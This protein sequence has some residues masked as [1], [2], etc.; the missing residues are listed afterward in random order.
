MLRNTKL[1]VAA[2]FLFIIATVASAFELVAYYTRLIPSRETVLLYEDQISGKWADLVVRLG[3]KGRVVFDRKTSY[4]P[5]WQTGTGRWS[6]DEIIPRNGDGEEA[7]PDLINRYSHV[8]LIKAEKDQV[9]VHWRYVPDFDNPGLTGVVDEYFT[10]SPDGLVSRSVRRATER[11]DD[12]LDPANVT[13]QVLKLNADGIEQLSLKKPSLARVPAEAVQGSPVKT[14][15][16]VK[17]AAWWKF[18][19]GLHERPYERKDLAVEQISGADCV[20]SGPKTLYKKGVSGTALEFDGYYT[21]VVLPASNAPQIDKALTV[22]AWV[23]LGAY[24][25]GWAPVVQQSVWG[26]SGYYLGMD[27]D[28]RPGFHV[29]VGGDWQSLTGSKPLGLFRWCHLAGTFDRRT[30]R[31]SLFVDGRQVASKEIPNQSITQAGTDLVIGLNTQKM[32]PVAGRVR[33]GKWPSMFGIDGLIDEVRIYTQALSEQRIEESYRLFAPAPEMV[34]KPDM[35]PRHWPVNPHN[36]PSETFGAKYTK[37]SYYETWDNIWR[38]SNHPDIL[39]GFDELPC[40]VVFWRGTSYGPILVTENGKWVGDQSSENYRMVEDAGEAEGCC[41]HMSDKQCRHSHVRLVENTDARVVVHW[42]YGLVDSRYYFV[43]A[44]NGWGDWADEY[45]II[46]PDGVAVRHLARGKTWY[47]SWVE[48]MFFSE[49]GTMPEDNVELAAYTLVNNE[50]QSRTYSWEN[51]SPECDLPK[52]LISMVNTKS[53]YRAFNVYPTGSSV[54]TFAGRTTPSHFHWWNHFPVSQITSDGRG[55]RA[56]DRAAHSSL[57]WG[58]PSKDYLMYGLTDKPADALLP[59]ARSWNNPP[60]I[61]NTQGCSSQGYQQAERAYHL[62]ALSDRLSFDLAGSQ[63]RPVVNPCFVIKHWGDDAA[64]SLKF[65]G[66]EVEPGRS[67]RQG[68]VVDTD[69]TKSKVIWVKQNADSVVRFELRKEQAMAEKACCSASYEQ[70]SPFER[71]IEVLKKNTDVVVLSS[72]TGGKVAVV[73][74]Y[75]GRVMTSSADGVLSFGWINR[76]LISSG[77]VKPQINAYGSEDRFWIGP[78]GGQ[79]S[80]FFDPDKPFQFKYWRTPAVIDT[81]PFELVCRSDEAVSFTRRAKLK[82]YSGTEFDIQI[83]RTVKLLSKQ[84]FA[85]LLGVEL[86]DD[87]R[88]VGYESQN[89]MTN[90]GKEPWRKETGLLSIWILGMMNRSPATT[91]VIPFKPGTEERLGPKVNDTYFGKVPPDRLIVKDDCLFFKVAGD[92][93]SKIGISPLRAK[94]VLGSYD[95]QNKVLTIV[96]YNKPKDVT[97]YVN[98]LWELQDEPYGGDVVNA[99]NDGPAKPGSKGLGDF[100]ELESSSPALELAVGESVFHVHRTFHIQADQAQLDKIARS[101]LGLDLE[102]IE[103]AFAS[104]RYSAGRHPSGS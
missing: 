101:I 89:R 103:N 58:L 17:P 74:A 99:Y 42:R 24:P 51:G 13:T 4:L 56:P 93:R 18:D 14:G 12:W 26:K 7:N 104:K 16:V 27:Q 8:R 88:L 21:G 78:E 38:V 40:R 55:A 92:F 79:F 86:G 59:L 52:P 76:E 3:D 25:F 34:D 32:P 94:P 22:E 31:I 96:Q 71:D 73:P 39:V 70:K 98:S 90:V 63:D 41:E 50:G 28:G 19:D 36:K 81:E 44:D 80:I 1:A 75:Q 85:R 82:N 54:K 69:G 84:D 91:V 65:N 47:D 29:A 66:H 102:Q 11:L 83:D 60:Y 61:T 5:Y 67:F 53:H 100:Y 87:A 45:W 9:V 20:V 2:L 10:I 64:A 49:P 48:T 23:T 37:L 15:Q 35:Q 97:D 46:Y 30:G 33:R 77:G 62:V 68:V 43:K 6:F 95:A 72:D 57:V